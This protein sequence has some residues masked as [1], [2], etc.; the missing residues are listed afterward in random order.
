VILRQAGE[1]REEIDLVDPLPPSRRP[2]ESEAEMLPP[3]VCP[4]GSPTSLFQAAGGDPLLP[5]QSSLD[6]FLH[7]QDHP[8]N[9]GESGGDL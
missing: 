8:L 7:E 4:D 3:S 5:G 9:P 1:P 6:G 2:Q